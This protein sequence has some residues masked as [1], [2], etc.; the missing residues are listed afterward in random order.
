MSFSP[1]TPGLQEPEQIYHG[2]RAAHHGTARADNARHVDHTGELRSFPNAKIYVG[3]DE[4]QAEELKG[5]GEPCTC[6]LHR[7]PLS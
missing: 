6:N 1:P 7:R 4:T 3:A 5:P 2:G